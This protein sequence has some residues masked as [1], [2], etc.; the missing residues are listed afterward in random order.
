ME[1][2][3]RCRSGAWL[4]LLALFCQLVIVAPSPAEPIGAMP[5]A[6]GTVICHGHDDGA[7]PSQPTP[8]HGPADCGYCAFCHS[9][10]AAANLAVP[11]PPSLPE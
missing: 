9:L 11:V 10:G 5:G 8:H 3:R 7:A 1:C 4:A 2:W 6:L